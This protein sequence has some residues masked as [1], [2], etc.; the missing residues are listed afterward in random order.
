[1]AEIKF[2]GQTRIGRDMN[3]ADH[4]GMISPP[5]PP[6]PENTIIATVIKVVRGCLGRIGIKI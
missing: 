3:V 4:G 6:K 2:T 5:P 1:M